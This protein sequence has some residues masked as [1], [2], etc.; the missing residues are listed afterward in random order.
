MPRPSD[1]IYQHKDLSRQAD[2]PN[3]QRITS[4]SFRN[5]LTDQITASEIYFSTFIAEHNIPF[6][7]AEHFN[8]LCKVMFPDSKIAKGFSCGR[9]KTTALV[10]YALHWLQY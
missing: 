6:L 10:K 1:T 3:Q 7:A 9:T 2:D 4:S 8:K 5:D